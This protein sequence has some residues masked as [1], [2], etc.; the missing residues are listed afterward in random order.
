MCQRCV[1]TV[2]QS[3]IRIPRTQRAAE[4]SGVQCYQLKSVLPTHAVQLWSLMRPHIPP[5]GDVQAPAG[6]QY[7]SVAVLPRPLSQNWLVSHRFLA[8]AGADSLT[9]A[10]LELARILV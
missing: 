8:R 6:A 10:D 2:R 4:R 7:T 5:R 1:P 3:L 9:Q